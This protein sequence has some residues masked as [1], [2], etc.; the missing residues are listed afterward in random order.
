MRPE[1]Q[2]GLTSVSESKFCKEFNRLIY[3]EFDKNFTC[4]IKNFKDKTME[5][6]VSA[7]YIIIKAL[8]R[9]VTIIGLTRGDITKVLHTEKRGEA[10]NPR[11]RISRDASGSRVGCK[12]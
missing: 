4:A 10:G 9:G 5:N 3:I 2:F 8:E 11:V 12:S 7:D 1:N 6:A